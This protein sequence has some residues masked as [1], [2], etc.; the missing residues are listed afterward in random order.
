ME[1]CCLC[2]CFKVQAPFSV[3]G[4]F[5]FFA[6]SAPMITNLGNDRLQSESNCFLI[7]SSQ[8][9]KIDWLVGIIWKGTSGCYLPREL[10]FLDQGAIL[11]HQQGKNQSGVF[12]IICLQNHSRRRRKHKAEKCAHI[13]GRLRSIC[14]S[15]W[16]V[17]WTSLSTCPSE[18]GKQTRAYVWWDSGKGCT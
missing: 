7:L 11:I 15:G 4:F 14:F 8:V 13:F 16:Q 18:G 1:A 2:S 9:L 12:Q 6:F 5:G 3:W 17:W 10:Y